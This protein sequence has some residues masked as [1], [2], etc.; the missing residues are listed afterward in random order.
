MVVDEV[1]ILEDAPPMLRSRRRLLTTQLVQK[2]FCPPPAILSSNAIS[3]YGSVAHFLA[4]VALVMH[5][6][7]LLAL[8]E[9]QSVFS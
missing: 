8:S 5:A 7:Q 3:Q 1:E 6:V 2:V 9:N 4:R